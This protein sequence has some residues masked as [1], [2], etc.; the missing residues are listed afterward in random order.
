MHIEQRHFTRGYYVSFNKKQVKQVIDQAELKEYEEK[1]SSHSPEKTD[2]KAILKTED[3]PI[4]STEISY[5]EQALEANERS[6]E[7]YKSAIHSHQKAKSI[8][9]KISSADPPKKNMPYS[10]ASSLSKWAGILILMFLAFAIGG[11][12]LFGANAVIGGVILIMAVLCM[13]ISFIFSIIA[14]R[15]LSP[16]SEAYNK[17]RFYRNFWIT[18]FIIGAI[19]FVLMGIALSQISL[20]GG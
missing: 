13:L 9:K 20:I 16:G 15:H 2:I 10:T 5:D 7:E 8:S 17:A 19:V 14:M 18:V 4:E 6:V 11:G 12:V 1:V 3:W